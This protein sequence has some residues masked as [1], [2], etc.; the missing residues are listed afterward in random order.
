MSTDLAN[1][2]KVNIYEMTSIGQAQPNVVFASNI[3]L[4]NQ[5]GAAAMGS[6]PVGISSLQ[7]TINPADPIVVPDMQGPDLNKPE[8]HAYQAEATGQ[9]L[10]SGFE[11]KNVG[12]VAYLGTSVANVT[13]ELFSSLQTKEPELE[14]QDPSLNPN[15][16]HLAMNNLAPRGP[17]VFGL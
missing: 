8:F 14:P 5:F 13:M 3:S 12:D 1:E 11:A 7:N 2:F 17:A 15:A 9:F 6:S 10:R 4:Q 16:P